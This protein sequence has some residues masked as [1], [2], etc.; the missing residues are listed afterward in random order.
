MQQLRQTAARVAAVSEAVQTQLSPI[1]WPL[2]PEAVQAQ[3][4]PIFWL[5]LL[6]AVQAHLSSIF[7][8]L[9]CLRLC[10]RS[11]HQFSGSC[12]PEAV[13][14]QFSPI[15]NFLIAV[16][17]AGAALNDVL[18]AVFWKLWR[19]LLVSFGC[20]GGQ[21]SSQLEESWQLLVALGGACEFLLVFGS[22]CPRNWNPFWTPFWHRNREKRCRTSKKTRPAQ[23]AKKSSISDAIL[24]GPL[25]CPDSK[26]HMFRRVCPCPFE[27]LRGRFGVPFGVTF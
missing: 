21:K 8:Q 23:Q 26:Y 17:C 19:P 1:F 27:W 20:R 5:L 4:S 15:L 24:C 25:C 22:P 2:L 13:Q 11:S 10:R 18:G 14:A 7:W 16:G 6:E 9:F 12:L 3:L